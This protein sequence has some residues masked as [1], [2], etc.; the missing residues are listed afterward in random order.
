MVLRATTKLISTKKITITNLS[1]SFLQI[2]Y[3]EI[4]KQIGGEDWRGRRRG[5]RWRKGYRVTE[6]EVTGR[7]GSGRG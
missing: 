3:L 4:Y 1:L 2:C 5:R 6:R 7:G